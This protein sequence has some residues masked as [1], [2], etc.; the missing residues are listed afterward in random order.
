MKLAGSELCTGCGACAK[1]CPKQA[2][3]FRDDEE[4]FPTPYIQSDKCIECGL[5][6]SICPALHMPQTHSIQKAYAAQI[7]D[8]DA[9][10]DSTS[11][12]VFTALSREIF[13]RGGVVYGCVWD[14]NYNAIIRK[15]EN[16]EEMNPMR[17]SKYVWSWAG[18]SF[19]QIKSYLENGRT[20]LFTG[21]PCQVA[22]LRSYLKK[23]YDNLFLI[24]LQC[25]AAPSPMALDKY[26][27]TIC[28]HDN[29][30]NLNL[31]FRDKNPYGIG[32]HITFNGYK[33]K[34][35]SKDEH[36]T[37]SYYYAFYSKLI[38]RKCC[39]RCIYRNR[40][41]VSEITIGDFWGIQKK[42]YSEMKI[43]AGVS[44]VLINTNKGAELMNAVKAHLLLVESKVEDIEFATKKFHAPGYRDAFFRVLK[45][46]G[47]AAAERKYLFNIPR[48]M[49]YFKQQLPPSVNKFIKKLNKF[50]IKIKRV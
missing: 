3:E 50:I 16:E 6:N 47:W 38:T 8:R 46:K 49:R 4:G 14:D 11:G 12:G 29:R 35:A 32:A 9:L 42:Y 40:E 21:L 27:D 1:A 7:T 13:K 18:D 10:K 26:L 15:A 19:P 45:T 43:N 33:K 24:D 41:R 23:D 5:C 44:S 31:K 28:S 39:Y 34:T 25:S 17:G 22:G 2:I 20:V 37:N 30:K 48:L 36:I